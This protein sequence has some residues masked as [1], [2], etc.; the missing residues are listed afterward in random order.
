MSDKV[1]NPE[2]EA[3]YEKMFVMFG[4][5]PVDFGFGWIQKDNPSTITFDE[6]MKIIV[7]G[8]VYGL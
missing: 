4:V 1:E 5:R 8:S 2:M 7:D 6:A 3:V